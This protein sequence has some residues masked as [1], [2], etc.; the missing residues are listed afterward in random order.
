VAGEITWG[1]E[2]VMLSAQQHP[3]AARRHGLIDSAD[4]VGVRRGVDDPWRRVRAGPLG[5]GTPHWDFGAR[6]T[7]LGLTAART[8]RAS[9][10]VLRA[11][12]PGEA[13]CGAAE[14]TPATRSRLR[15]DGGMSAT[16]LRQALASA[17]AGSVS[18]R[19]EGDDA[20][21]GVPGEVQPAYGTTCR[22]V[23]ALAW[24]GGRPLWPTRSGGM[25]PGLARTHHGFPI[26]TLDF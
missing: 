15:V 13:W 22:S 6:G 3:V 1:V 23:V 10:G 19:V 14:L 21:S 8:G 20:G 7:L 18:S 5:L 2:A 24:G 17:T 11:S 12:P 26:S 4:G 25:G 9:C 16:H